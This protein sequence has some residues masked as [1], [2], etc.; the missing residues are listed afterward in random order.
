MIIWFQGV[1]EKK[2]NKGILKLG[3]NRSGGVVISQKQG[4]HIIYIVIEYNISCHIF[5]LLSHASMDIAW[6]RYFI[7]IFFIFFLTDFY[8][9]CTIISKSK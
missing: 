2:K 7:S 5:C 3:Q 4:A 8:I 1:L 6:T 9:L